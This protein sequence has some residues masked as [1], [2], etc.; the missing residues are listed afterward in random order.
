MK[1]HVVFGDIAMKACF[2]FPIFIS[3]R[4]TYRLQMIYLDWLIN[5]SILHKAEM[6]LDT[7]NIKE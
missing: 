4:R 5:L 3:F 7:K 1:I 2:F 6:G